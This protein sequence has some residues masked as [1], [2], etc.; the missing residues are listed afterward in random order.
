MILK[1][2]NVERITD[3]PTSIKRL[4][5]E[6]YAPKKERPRYSSMLKAD[7]I[8]IAEKKGIKTKGLKKDELVKLLEGAR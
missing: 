2:F 4:I 8:R 1:R 3:D 7:L 5:A 6:G